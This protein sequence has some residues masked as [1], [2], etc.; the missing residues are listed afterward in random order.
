MITWLPKH[1]TD[2][3][4]VLIEPQF[5]DPPFCIIWLEKKKVQ[6]LFLLKVHINNY[7]SLHKG[8]C[9][10]SFLSSADSFHN[11]LFSQYISGTLSYCQRNRTQIKMVLIA[12]ERLFSKRQN[13]GLSRGKLTKVS[14]SAKI[15]N[16]YNQ[17]P[18][19]V[20]DTNGSKA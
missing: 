16:R 13:S 19:L 1:V 6:T 12:C 3:S 17:E 14:K 2:L 8:I 20:Q 9:F 10:L 7:N 15:K 5:I 18:H 11:S 4:P